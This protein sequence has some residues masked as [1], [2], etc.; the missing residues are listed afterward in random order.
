MFRFGARGTS[1]IR[2]VSKFTPISAL[3]VLTSA[4]S[5][6]TVIV[7]AAPDTSSRI[8]KSALWFSR[9]TIGPWTYREKPRFST[10][11]S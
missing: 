2:L 5:L 3:V 1:E 6:V 10:I 7:S 9:R 8:V 11:T 4:A